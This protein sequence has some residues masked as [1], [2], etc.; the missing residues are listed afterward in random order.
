MLAGLLAPGGAQLLFVL[1]VR[2]AGPAR[3]SVIAGAAPL[4]AVTIA[5]VALGEPATLPLIAGA[6]L[7][8]AGGLALIAERDRP[9]T[10][11]MIGL[12][13]SFGCVVLFATRD[14]VVRHIA[15]DS[16]AAPQ[17][18]ASVTILSGTV[19]IFL[20]L[21]ACGAPG[22]RRHRPRGP[23]FHPAGPALGR[24]LRVPLRGL[25]P[26]ARLGRQPARRDGVAV[27]R[28]ARRP[29]PAT[30]R[31][32]RTAPRAR[33]GAGGR[34]RGADRR[35]PLA[36]LDPQAAAAPLTPRARVELRVRPPRL[37]EREQVDTGGDTG[38][39]V[40]DDLETNSPFSTVN[41]IES[42][43]EYS[44]EFR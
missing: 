41:G 28:P 40:D 19:L 38:A 20:V 13:Y 9:E 16:T 12:V 36:P 18:A 7:I 6:V 27:R 5:I 22:L 23:V 43:P 26:L 4:V 25:L 31:T 32:R 14:N 37:R 11:R 3:S 17:L 34:R 24:V 35:V 44:R 10:F 21:V 29:A 33:C 39:A 15:H 1:A 2:E 42:S 8:V 30:H